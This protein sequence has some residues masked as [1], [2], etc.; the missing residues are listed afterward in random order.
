MDISAACLDQGPDTRCLR[1]EAEISKAGLNW[2]GKGDDEM[3]KTSNP[4][5][6]KPTGPV[7]KVEKKEKREGG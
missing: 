2:Q 6:R 4:A 5:E 1:W 3:S 7:T